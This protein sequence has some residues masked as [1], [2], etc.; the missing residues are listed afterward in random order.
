MASWNPE[1]MRFSKMKIEES[2]AR[3][4]QYNEDLLKK[5]LVFEATIQD[6]V[7]ANAKQMINEINVLIRDIKE[8][9]QA[10]IDKMEKAAEGIA[11]LESGA[12]DN[13]KGFK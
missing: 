10:Q 2:L 8:K 7:V 12:S 4:E 9:T 3:M 13:M 5:V 6:E 11:K 1:I